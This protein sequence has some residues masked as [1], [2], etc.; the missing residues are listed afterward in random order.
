MESHYDI[1][2][3][4]GGPAGYAAAIRASQLGKK[5]CLI[6]KDGLGGTCLNAGCIPTKALLHVSNTFASFKQSSSIG[7]ISDHFHLDWSKVQSYKQNVVKKLTMGV[8]YLMEK[9]K[10]DVF[11][12]TAAFLDEK[13]L[14]INHEH[15]SLIASDY[16]VLCTG[17]SSSFPLVDGLDRND[18]YIYDSARILNIDKIP[19]KLV[20]IGGGIIG[21][22]FAFIFATLGSDVTVVEVMPQVLSDFDPDLAGAALS[23]LKKRGVKFHTDTKIINVFQDEQGKKILCSRTGEEFSLSAEA[24]L[25]ATGRKPHTENLNLASLAVQL[26]PD[27]A[28]ETNEFLQ[29]GVPH[30]YAAGDVLGKHLFAHVAYKE[31][32]TAV[33]NALGDEDEKMP[34]DYRFIPKVLFLEPQLASVGM[35]EKE[36]QDTGYNAKVGMFP[37]NS[38][39]KASILREAAGFMKVVVDNDTGDMLGFHLCAPH[40]GELINTGTLA[41]NLEALREEF[42]SSIFVH[43]SISE[44]LHEASLATEDKVLHM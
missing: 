27:G 39:G 20:I 37:L 16:F 41:L 33:A 29:T 9:N 14:E 18:P 2:I 12:G 26:G 15:K 10:V 42:G 25:V 11:K 40:A 13:S 1:S 36:A 19:G 5:V 32:T 3:V 8:A 22:E 31:A 23:C 7:I 21:L 6:E 34:M 44:A 24:I 28:V 17:A 35:T 38:N 30:I 4:G 43:P